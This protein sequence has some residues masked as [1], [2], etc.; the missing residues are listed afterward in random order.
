MKQVYKPGDY[1]IDFSSI[2]EV[3]GVDAGVLHYK[4][5]RGTDKVFTASIPVDNLS[6]TSLRNLLT[7]VE[8]EKIL[9]EL[10]KPLADTYEYNAHQ[11]KEDMYLNDPLKVVPHLKYFWSK[12]GVLPRTDRELMAE[13]M[14]HISLEIEFVTNQPKTTVVKQLEKHLGN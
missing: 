13:M 11:I 6:R 7:T 4:P 12:A 2:Y 10:T 8:I 14:D 1:I 5:I 3:T 9:T